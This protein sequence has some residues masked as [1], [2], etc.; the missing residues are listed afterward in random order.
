MSLQFDSEIKHV[1]GEKVGVG[2]TGLSVEDFVTDERQAHF[3]L[4]MRLRTGSGDAYPMIRQ[5][6][7]LSVEPRFSAC[8]TRE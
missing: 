8:H 4:G 7:V 3:Q 1:F 6:A 5:P 2:V